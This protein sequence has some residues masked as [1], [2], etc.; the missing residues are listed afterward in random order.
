M[1]KKKR[2]IGSLI[3]IV[4]FFSI[5]F[6]LYFFKY[7]FYGLNYVEKE[8][9]SAINK[10][11]YIEIHLKGAIR[12]KGIYLIKKDTS[13]KELLI[14]AQLLFKADVSKLDLSRRLVKKETIFIPYKKGYEIKIKWADLVE[15]KQ[16][17]DHDI[18]KS[19][20]KKIIKFKEDNP[21]WVT[22]EA[23]QTISGVGP[24]TISKLQNIITLDQ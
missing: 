24:V 17:I 8:E 5:G 7:N 2:I 14:Q 15:E 20:A 3:A 6:S 10:E 9:K 23:L 18:T 1:Q 22:W 4:I 11:D 13:L 21:Q 16:L 19:I 12:A